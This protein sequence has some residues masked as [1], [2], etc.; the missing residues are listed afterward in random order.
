MTST[1]IQAAIQRASKGI[2][3]YE[4]LMRML[5]TV[6]V[7]TDRDFQRRYNGFY[8]VR[9]RPPSWY[10]NYYALMQKLKLGCGNVDFAPVLEEIYAATGRSFFFQQARGDARP[11]QACLGYLCPFQFG[12]P[13]TSVRQ[14]KQ[15]GACEGSVSIDRAVVRAVPGICRR[16][17]LY[18]GVRLAGGESRGNH[19][20]QEGRLYSV[21][22]AIG[23]PWRRT[24]GGQRGLRTDS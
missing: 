4:E 21:A 9:S 7:S 8:R 5:P 22:D 15:A 13:A 20:R 10:P 23:P 2:K 6:D 16:A 1:E 18:S 14:Q 3:Q 24:H 11:R 19:E 17:T 12:T